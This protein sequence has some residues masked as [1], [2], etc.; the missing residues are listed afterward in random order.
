MQLNDLLMYTPYPGFY[1]CAEPYGSMGV[2]DNAGSWYTIEFD[3]VYEN[4]AFSAPDGTCDGCGTVSH[5]GDVLGEVC[6]DPTPVIDW[7]STPW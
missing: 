6:I 4:D 3:V 5:E 1:P 7:E 2:R